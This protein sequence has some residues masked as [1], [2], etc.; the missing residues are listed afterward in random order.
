MG[1]YAIKQSITGSLYVKLTLLFSH[2]NIVLWY[3]YEKQ[4][5]IEMCL[6]YI[7]LGQ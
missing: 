6:P 1:K 5:Y 2:D 3:Y 4:T 7:Y